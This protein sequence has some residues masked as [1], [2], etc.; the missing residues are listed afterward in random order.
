MTASHPAGADEDGNPRK[1]LWPSPEGSAPT[2]PQDKNALTKLL[3]DVSE[4]QESLLEDHLL[5]NRI[6]LHRCS[7]YCLRVPRS[8]NKSIK[9][10][11]MEFG[12]EESPSKDLRVSPA[13]VKDKNG[14][15]RLEMA[16]D[17][18]LLVQHS[19]YYTQV[20]RANGDISL[21]LSKSSPDNPSVDEIMA[22]EKYITGYACKG[23]EAT[24]AVV[25]LFN[26][27]ANAA[28]ESSG[29]TAKSVCT[30]LLMDTV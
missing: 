22:T 11:R 25:E 8:R 3:M 19:K 14:S 12:N 7:D 18:P 17:H 9:E 16:R 23:N 5:T 21:I 10:C 26:D 20:W 1:H 2:P 15:L 13:I 30:K 4:S 6:N 24:G 28:D 29:A 27:M